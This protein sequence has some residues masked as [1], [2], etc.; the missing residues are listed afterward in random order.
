MNRF[1]KDIATMD[2]L[3]FGF[4]ELTDYCVKCLFSLALVIFMSPWILVIAVFSF[5]YLASIRRKNLIVNRDTIRL[6][7]SLMSPVNS[8]I[9]DAVNGLPTLR[10]LGQQNYFQRIL[11]NSM[12]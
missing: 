3:V 4:L 6:K 5:F 8:L 12:D 1:S 11:Y 9:Q 2:N 10:C 7:Y